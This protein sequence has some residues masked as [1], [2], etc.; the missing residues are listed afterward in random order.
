LLTDSNPYSESQFK[1]LK[2]RLEFPERF[3][4]LEDARAHCQRFFHWYNQEHRHSGI[5]LMTPHAVHYGIA[6]TLQAQRAQTLQRA[7]T[8]QPLRFKGRTPQPPELPQ[9]PW[10]N[11]PKEETTTADITNTCSLISCN[12]VFHN[13]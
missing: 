3:G 7:F 8:A 5:A 11:P 1:A 6:E 13:D 10:I 2:Y 9:A 12:Q 4:S